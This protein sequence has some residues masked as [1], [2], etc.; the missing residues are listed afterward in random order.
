MIS[1][2]E[3]FLLCPEICVERIVAGLSIKLLTTGESVSE[4]D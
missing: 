2:V 3:N 4:K 1:R